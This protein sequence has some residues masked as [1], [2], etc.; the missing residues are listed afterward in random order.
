[1]AQPLCFGQISFALTQPSLGSLQIL[2][3]D[4][5]SIPL[6]DPS[7][8]VTQRVGT[9]Q[10]PSIFTIGTSKSRF[11]LE[12]DTRRYRFLPIFQMVRSIVRM[13]QRRPAGALRLLQGKIEIGQ[14]TL[15]EEIAISVGQVGPEEYRCVID[16]GTQLVFSSFMPR[17]LEC[18]V[19]ISFCQLRSS[20]RNSGFKLVSPSHDQDHHEC[21]N[22]EHQAI[23]DARFCTDFGFEEVVADKPRDQGRENAGLCAAVPERPRDR[24]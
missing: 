5:C 19:L 13:E 20:L 23:Q 16:N 24:G 22:Q 1:M 18:Q 9:V 14:P 3:I 21:K 11:G 6:D 8:F 4:V 17:D 10:E 2:N 15:I 7:R 12:R